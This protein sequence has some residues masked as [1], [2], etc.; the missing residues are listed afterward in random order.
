L[1]KNDVQTST[2]NIQA[3]CVPSKKGEKMEAHTLAEKP[4][5][6]TKCVKQRI[7]T[8]GPV[9]SL[10]E[11]VRPDWWRTMF[12]SF[13]LKTDGDV[14]EDSAI[15]CDEVD[16]F[17]RILDLSPENSILDLCCGQ[18]RHT[19]E[20][21]RRG[22]IHIEGLDRSHYLI[23]K[24][25][26]ITLKDG[27]SIK[28][29]EG[30]ARKLPY[31]TDSFDVVLILGNSFGYFETVSD[32]EHV[33]TE[34]CRVLKP[35]GRILIDITDGEYVAAHYQPRSWEWIDKKHFVCRE[36]TLSRSSD[37]LISREVINHVEKGVLA[38]QF[39]AERLYTKDSL[40]ELLKVVGFTNIVFHDELTP[41][42]QRNQD[43]GMME[44]RIVLTA[45]MRKNWTVVRKKH[46]A[47]VK[48]VAVLLGDH[49]KPDKILPEHI[50]DDDDLYTIDQLKGTLRE[51]PGY[52]F[53]Y[54]DNHDT[55]IQE[56]QKLKNN[57]DYVFNLCDNGFGNDPQKE[58]HI[59]ALIEMLG[60]SYTGAN[61]QCLAY[62][63]DKSLVRGI[64]N[65]MNIRVPNAFMVNPEDSTFKLPFEFPVI[66]KPNFGDSSFGITQRSVATTHDA[67]ICAIDEIRD[68]FGYEKPI[69]IEECL[70]GSDL[71]VGIIG[72]PPESYVFLPIIQEDYSA[73]PEHL[74]R[75]CGYEAKWLVDSPYFR[76]LKSV[77][78]ILLKEI[79]DLIE[80]WSIKLFSRLECR[81]YCRFDWRLDDSGLPKLL[82]VNPNPGWCWD[83]HLAKMA[84]F[85]GKSYKEM[86][87]S[88][89]HAAERRL[90]ILQQ[91]KVE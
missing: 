50:F 44:R 46:P 63:Y 39:Y 18:G 12:N 81:D 24:A 1:G 15:T 53:T 71:T 17:S 5:Q 76:L 84:K 90:D 31:R 80:E 36:R 35:W 87:I 68:K 78:A 13:Y 59:P 73:L 56:L 67:L 2:W 14:V 51:L 66:A 25:K 37:R 28:F 29:R 91:K 85:A 62:C 33:L 47:S 72:N 41:N 32:D 21:A 88:I 11:H 89:L 26:G 8:L 38:D 64:A 43:L 61:P 19:I 86:L 7:K 9:V 16:I 40:S 75:I 10:E 60:L 52:Q 55:F 23:K 4:P 30:D 3:M 74:P 83:G 65:E 22:F 34:V 48:R 79:Q 6:L 82:E 57:V 58:L 54:I 70:T 49:T 20:L 42:S 69:V 77:P 45:T 27:L